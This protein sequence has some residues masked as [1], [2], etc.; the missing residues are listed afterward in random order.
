MKISANPVVSIV[1]VVLLLFQTIV[2]TGVV[3]AQTKAK[4]TQDAKQAQLVQSTV[5]FNGKNNS[6]AK[7]LGKTTPVDAEPIQD[8][9]GDLGISAQDFAS[10]GA[11]Q[12]IPVLP[13]ALGDMNDDG[14]INIWDLLRI[15]NIHLEIGT[16]ATAFEQVEGDMNLDLAIDSIDLAWSTDVLLR[17]MGV[18]HVIDASGG[19][20]VG[21]GG[22]TTVMFLPNSFAEPKLLCIEDLPKSELEELLQSQVSDWGSD[23]QYLGGATLR[24]LNPTPSDFGIPV[25]IGFTE[26]IPEG[27][28]IPTDGQ[29]VIFSIEPDID[30][31]GI[32]EMNR[33][34]NLRQNFVSMGTSAL[35]LE[36]D[37]VESINLLSF[38]RVRVN[39]D[40]LT[41]TVLPSNPVEPG[42]YVALRGNGWT[43]GFEEDYEV[44]WIDNSDTIV[45]TPDI[46][47]ESESVVLDSIRGIVTL[48]PWLNE[49]TY[50]I[51]VW[52]RFD[53]K[54]GNSIQLEVA[55]LIGTIV[56]NIRDSLATRLSLIVS[57]LSNDLD[58][59]ILVTEYIDLHSVIT[60]LR[61]S[62]RSLVD[63]LPFI[64]DSSFDEQ[65]SA[66]MIRA[67]DNAFL[68]TFALS[69]SFGVV[70]AGRNDECNSQ[71]VLLC[72]KTCIEQTK[73]LEKG[74]LTGF[75][76]KRVCGAS[77]GP[78]GGFVCN[79]LCGVLG[80]LIPYDPKLPS[81][82]W[83]RQGC[84]NIVRNLTKN[85]RSASQRGLQ[86]IKVNTVDRNGN[87]NGQ[88]SLDTP[89]GCFHY[90][91]D[92]ILG[93]GDAGTKSKVGSS[94]SASTSINISKK[95]DTQTTI[96]P[97]TIIGVAD[98]PIPISKGIVGPDGLAIIPF[99]VLTGNVR[100]FAFD[101][102]TGFFDP[103]IA[104]INISAIGER[105]T[106][107]MS[108]MPDTSVV[109]HILPID[110]WATD[111]IATG[112]ARFECRVFIPTSLIGDSINIGFDAR[113][114]LSFRMQDPNDVFL[115]RDSLAAC[116][117]IYKFVPTQSGTHKITIGFGANGGQGEFT[118]GVSNFPNPPTPFLCGAIPYDTLLAGFFPYR[119][120]QNAFVGTTD[121]LHIESGVVIEF[122]SGGFLTAGG[123]LLP[124]GSVTLRPAI[125]PPGG[126][127]SSNLT[128]TIS[129]VGF[130]R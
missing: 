48:V 118:V 87:P 40:L 74:W 100:I 110:T 101:P 57:V 72:S 85:L 107:R 77:S 97:G 84:C 68:S 128:E 63:A 98:S 2:T 121:T 19:E 65:L 43:S 22:R 16:P 49:G 8:L 45:T 83:C 20:V 123:L 25:N 126:V 6:G 46:V 41:V 96:P 75:V 95:S 115:F 56:P 28:S 21:N 108:Y 124:Q 9:L 119:I 129:T 38:D 66:D 4:A 7:S 59:S 14:I 62:L 105:A 104:T 112:S 86:G 54:V 90:C 37:S 114:K 31:D 60:A 88:K 26:L 3:E 27:I 67:F 82:K 1:S 30:G 51:R 5:G 80:G 29:N 78:F 102:S 125:G 70:S 12:G 99:N 130:D 55:P 10:S 81:K 93:V 79:K 52:N 106:F 64:P 18:P 50:S 36:P 73:D 58:D 71:N 122:E 17:R 35:T 32:P 120:A 69:N 92:G 89:L 113:Q 13:N 111:T 103:E 44:W 33:L 42:E 47:L 24:L 76:C 34:G 127:S 15:R 91:C 11:F 61:D 94:S 39:P 116:K 117:N 23:I 109:I 53:G